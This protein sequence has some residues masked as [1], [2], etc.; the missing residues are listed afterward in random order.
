MKGIFMAEYTDREAFIPYRKADVIE[1]CIQDG[2]LDAQKQQKFREFCEILGAY[3]HFEFHEL[4]EKFKNNYA[5][6]NPDSDTKPMVNWTKEQLKEK[7]EKSGKNSGRSFA[8]C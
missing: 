7:E 4:L 3:Y 5:P 1:L 6:F 2:K 8:A